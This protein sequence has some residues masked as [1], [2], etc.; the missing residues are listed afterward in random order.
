[1]VSSQWILTIIIT[2]VITEEETN[3]EAF[4][5]NMCHARVP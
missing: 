1:M 2:I 4:G 5:H 3:V